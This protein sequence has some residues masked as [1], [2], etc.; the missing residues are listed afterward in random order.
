LTSLRLHV[1]ARTLLQELAS[2]VS[3]PPPAKLR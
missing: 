1:F 3:N 2:K